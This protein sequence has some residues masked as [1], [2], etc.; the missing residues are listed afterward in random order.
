MRK[1]KSRPLHWN[2]LNLKSDGHAWQEFTCRT[3]GPHSDKE[4]TFLNRYSQLGDRQEKK[5]AYQFVS[6]I[7][8]V[9]Y[10]RWTCRLV[11]HE[12]FSARNHIVSI[13]AS[14]ESNNENAFR[15]YSLSCLSTNSRS[16][17]GMSNFITLS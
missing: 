6:R 7:T 5:I 2:S 8:P 1:F 16:V 15:L 11:M 9:Y 14:S 10:Y 12:L 17:D 3:V 4:L 13:R